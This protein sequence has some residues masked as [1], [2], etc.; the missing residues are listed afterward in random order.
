M[1]ALAESERLPDAHPAR[2]HRDVGHEAHL[3][4]QRVALPARVEPEY[5]QLPAEGS[6]PEDRLERGGLAGAVRTDEADDASRLDVETHAIEGARRAVGLAQSARFNYCCHRLYLQGLRCWPPAMGSPA[7]PRP[8]AAARPAR[9][10]GAGWWRRPAA[11]P[12]RGSAGARP[13]SAP[14]ARPRSRT[15]RGRGASR[16]AAHRPAAGSP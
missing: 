16:P 1:H 9:V 8:R 13:S 10:R 4:H 11:T 14:C 12:L 7:P 5:L 15:Y 2:Q 6:K 3:A